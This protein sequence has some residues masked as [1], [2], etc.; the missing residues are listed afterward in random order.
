[1]GAY[2]DA[3]SNGCRSLMAIHLQDTSLVDLLALHSSSKVKT[4]IHLGTNEDR[5]MSEKTI[6]ISARQD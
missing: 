2:G 6:N 4:D 1:M 5:F 3:I